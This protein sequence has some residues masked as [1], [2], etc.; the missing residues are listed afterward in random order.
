MK[1][2]IFIADV[3]LQYHKRTVFEWGYFL[4]GFSGAAIVVMLLVSIAQQWQTTPA[5]SPI[6]A[7]ETGKPDESKKVMS[8]GEFFDSVRRHLGGSEPKGK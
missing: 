7:I 3:D 8:Y 6:I 2:S 5:Q 1:F 4:L